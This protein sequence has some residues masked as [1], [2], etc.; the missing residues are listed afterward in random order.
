M[1]PENKRVLLSTAYLPNIQYFSKLLSYPEVIVEIHDT[2]QKQTYRNRAIILGA[3]GPLDLIIPVKRPDGNRTITKNVLIDY[4][5]P[6]QKTHWRAIVSAYKN[7]PFFDFFE[8]ELSPIF[9]KQVKYL[10]D[11]NFLLVE[12]IMQAVGVRVHYQ[13]SDSYLHSAGADDFR[14]T[15]HPKVRMQLPDADFEQVRYFQ[16]FEH[17]LGFVPNLS[18]IDLLFNEGSQAVFLCKKC[19]KKGQPDK[20]APDNPY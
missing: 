17:K 19:M 14:D 15:I 18:F 2:Y 11:L 16:V 1:F 8:P 7:S 4:D 5:M 20:V 3:N 12:N 10:I 6:W 13:K 9:N